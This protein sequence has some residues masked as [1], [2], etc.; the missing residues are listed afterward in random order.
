V[1]DGELFPAPLIVA[2]LTEEPMIKV[3]VKQSFDD[4]RPIAGQP[5]CE[6]A[7]SDAADVE[8]ALDAA[9]DGST[10]TIRPR[11][12]WPAARRNSASY[13]PRQ[14]KAAGLN[15]AAAALPHRRERWSA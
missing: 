5:V 9:K 3:D 12:C 6:I 14:S 11:T 15:H 13:R 2:A 8:A 10:T 7:R 1:F 4:V